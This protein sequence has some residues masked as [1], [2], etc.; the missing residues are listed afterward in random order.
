MEEVEQT[1]KGATAT[2]NGFVDERGAENGGT[3]PFSVLNGGEQCQK[4]N[5]NAE[6]GADSE[7]LGA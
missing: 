7:H 5:E 6:T 2:T 4:D 1:I 3:T